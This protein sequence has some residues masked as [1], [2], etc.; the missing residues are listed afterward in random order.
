MIF[1]RGLIFKT[2]LEQWIGFKWMEEEK[3]SKR[4]KLLKSRKIQNMFS[5]LLGRSIEFEK[6]YH[7][8]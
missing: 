5:K 6:L 4:M 2:D 1:M 3:H 7:L 8:G